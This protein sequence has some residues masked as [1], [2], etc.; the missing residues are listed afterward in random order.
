M[1]SWWRA[2]WARRSGRCAAAAR[3]RL[4]ERAQPVTSETL[5]DAR[6][7]TNDDLHG[8]DVTVHA[9]EIVGAGRA[10]GPG[11]S[12]LARA[13]FGADAVEGTLQVKG[14]RVRW[15]SPRDAIRAGLG[16]CAADRTADGIIPYMSVR[17]NLT[18]A[19]AARALAGRAW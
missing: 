9:G 14:E 11:R 7:L 4:Q 15:D 3:D 16:F 13:I 1:W 2:C 10:A 12:E 8:V 18:L 5:L 6:D 17:E 19:G